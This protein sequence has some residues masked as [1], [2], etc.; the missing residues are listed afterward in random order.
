MLLLVGIISAFCLAPTCSAQS[1]YEIRNAVVTPEYGYEDFTYSAQVWMSDQA[2][3]RV[4]AIAVTKFSMKLNIY[5]DGKQIQSDSF[6]QTG[7]VKSSF[8]FGPYN[9]KNR[10]GIAETENA[11]FEIIFYAGGQQMAKTKKI[12]GPIV[13]PPTTTGIQFDRAPYFFQG[14]TA[15]AGFKDQDALDPKPACH[16]ML[17]GPIGT[18][19]SRT[20]NS[21]DITCRASGKSTYTCTLNEDLSAYRDGGNFSFMLVYNNL[22]MDPLTFGP[23]NITLRPYTPVAESPKID[24]NLD[25]TNFTIQA[26]VKDA[27]ANMEESNPQGRLIISHPWKGDIIYTSS[28]PEISGERVVFRW[29]Q[30]NDPAL[31]NRSD[32]ELSKIAPFTARLEYTNDKWDFSARSS[33]VTFNVVEEVPKLSNPSIPENVY[34]SS[35]ETSTQDMTATVAFSK[36]PGDLDVRL[37][38]PSMDF[39]STEKGTPLGGNK[40][41]YKWQ[42]QFDDIHVN[43]NYTLSLSFVHDQVEGGRYDFDNRSIHVSPVSVQ[44]LD[45]GVDAPAGQWNDSYTYSLKMNSTVPVKVQLQVYDPCSN[46][47]I[48]KQTKDAAVGAATVLNW[49]LQPFAYECREMAGQSAKF[50]FKAIFVGEEIASSRAYDG[51]SFLGAKPILISL[52]PE[53]DP[54]MVYVSEEGSSGSVS[55]TVEFGAGQGEAALRLE[56]LDGSLKMEE[57]SQG[58]A[59]GGNR[60]RYDWNLPFDKTDA[61]KSFNLSISYKHATLSGEYPL[62]KKTVT[63]QPISIEFGEGK[64]S[65]DKGRWNDTFVYSVPVSSS[66]NATVKLEVY[67]PCSHIW[68]QRASGKVSAGESIL[69]MTAQPFKSKCADSEGNEASYRFTA[70]FGDKT[71]ESDVYLGPTISGGQPKLVSVDFEPVLHVSE[72]APAYQSVKAIVDFPQGQDAMQLGIVGPNKSPATEEI[73]GVYLGGTQYLYTWSKDFGIEDAGNYT[74]SLRNAHPET[75][76]G[77]ISFSG[78]MMVVS[79]KIGSGQEP[80]AIGDVNYLPVLFVTPDTGARQAFSAEVFSPGGQGA[81]TL[82]LTGKGKNKH[83]ETSVTDL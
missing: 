48:E 4:G 12:L 24:K 18:S 31:F 10:F 62:A 41:Q 68:V 51:P 43:N 65:P 54:M 55:A 79:E 63:V 67:N 61:G 11:S 9:F 35:G 42:V 76:G 66:V 34:V 15:S 27:S 81:L 5:N 52:S 28:D 37:T 74:I 39:K 38:G 78:T 23:Y 30:E 32:V 80:K 53:S 25:Y 73:N 70:G 64:V 36:G 82:N 21:E 3:S 44:F 13:K 2:A 69:N 58:I 26:T 40:Y 20:W 56:G 29:T 17:T 16:L 71:S 57:Q 75:A 45:A 1:G 60:Y 50:R 59:L 49:T 6:D 77:E 83:T 8:S 14:I 72:N 46:D 19:E 33:N 47:W 22:K 7:M